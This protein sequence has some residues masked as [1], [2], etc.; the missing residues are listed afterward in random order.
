MA[1][2]AP[3]RRRDM[4]TVVFRALVAGTIACFMTACIAEETL[5]LACSLY[6]PT[7]PF[8][9]YNNLCPLW[10]CQCGF[11]WGYAWRLRTHGPQPNPWYV[12][13]RYQGPYS[14]D[15]CML[16]DRLCGRWGVSTVVNIPYK[17]RLYAPPS[18]PVVGPSI[19]I[20]KPFQVISPMQPLLCFAYLF[21]YLCLVSLVPKNVYPRH[22]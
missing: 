11:S 14:W 19:C 18:P 12:Q 7:D 8:W 20:Q 9:N 16:H 3:S 10:L 15:C 22:L 2:L 4:A 6:H 21:P 13:G 5:W 17:F 1:P